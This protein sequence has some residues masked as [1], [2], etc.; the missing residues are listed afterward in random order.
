MN[1]SIALNLTKQL[2]NVTNAPEGIGY[3]IEFYDLMHQLIH[4]LFVVAVIFLLCFIIV[5]FVVKTVTSS[6]RVVFQYFHKIYKGK[7]ITPI[8]YISICIVTA[9]LYLLLYTLSWLFPGVG[10][11]GSLRTSLV[12]VFHVVFR[13]AIII[14]DYV[15]H[16]VTGRP[17]GRTLEE[18][19]VAV[20]ISMLNGQLSLF[21]AL[22]GSIGRRDTA[23]SGT[24]VHLN[25]G[26]LN[27]ELRTAAQETCK[28]KSNTKGTNVGKTNNNRPY[29]TLRGRSFTP[30]YIS[31][32][33]SQVKVYNQEEEDYYY[34]LYDEW[35]TNWD[36]IPDEIEDEKGFSWADEY[37]DGDETWGD[38]VNQAYREVQDMLDDERTTMTDVKM[39]GGFLRYHREHVK[40]G[41]PAKKGKHNRRGQEARET[42]SQENFETDLI[43]FICD[44]I[45]YA[46]PDFEEVQKAVMESYIESIDDPDA[47]LP[48][49]IAVTISKCIYQALTFSDARLLFKK[50]VRR[51]MQVMRLM[52]RDLTL[53]KVTGERPKTQNIEFGRAKDPHTVKRD[54]TIVRGRLISKPEGPNLGVLDAA[55]KYKTV[56]LKQES[57]TIKM[58]HPFFE[59]W[60]TNATKQHTYD[61]CTCCDA[62]G[63]VYAGHIFC[64]DHLISQ[65]YE[66]ISTSIVHVRCLGGSVIPIP[67]HLNACEG[68]DLCPLR[69]RMRRHCN[70]QECMDD[71]LFPG[72]IYRMCIRC[73]EMKPV[74]RFSFS[75]FGNVF[76]ARLCSLCRYQRDITDNPMSEDTVRTPGPL[77]LTC[78]MCNITYA[79]AS[80]FRSRST[81]N[82]SDLCSKC[83]VIRHKSRQPERVQH[84]GCSKRQKEILRMF[85]VGNF[86]GL[87]D[88]YTEVGK[89]TQ[90][91]EVSDNR[92]KI[93]AQAASVDVLEEKKKLPSKPKPQ[94][95]PSSVKRSEQPFTFEAPPPITTPVPKKTIQPVKPA[96]APVY[97]DS[98]DERDE[99]FVACMS[100][101]KEMFEKISERLTRIENERKIVATG[102]TGAKVMKNCQTQTG[103]PKGVSIAIQCDS[104]TVV[105]YP[106][107]KPVKS[108]IVV[109]DQQFL[110]CLDDEIESLTKMNQET[111]L[112][113]EVPFIH[114]DCLVQLDYGGNGRMN[115]VLVGMLNYNSAL[116]VAVLRILTVCHTV[117]KTIFDKTIDK[118]AFCPILAPYFSKILDFATEQNQE[119]PMM[120]DVYIKMQTT[121]Q[122]DSYVLSQKVLPAAK[123]AKPKVGDRVMSFVC[124]EDAKG[125][126]VLGVSQGNVTDVSEAMGVIECQHDASVTTPFTIQGPGS[127]G[128][129]VVLQGTRTLPLGLHFGGICRNN[130][131]VCYTFPHK[132]PPIP[133]AVKGWYK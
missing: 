12:E 19:F 104:E 91:T 3:L 28:R 66:N 37:D 76:Y 98:E 32:G 39:A 67:T 126:V 24:V 77:S 89:K 22:I 100:Q 96:A 7:Y 23:K 26:D 131:N 81:K 108:A 42:Y 34:E 17:S 87:K 85:S 133:R 53:K 5:K 44:H 111:M 78:S 1:C 114:Q 106:K 74:E 94:P 13:P 63:F 30:T 31:I 4:F 62:E 116:S 43:K 45:G 33:N 80:E 49:P 129:L 97:E 121:D 93:K 112:R 115:G 36:L 20:V 92:E 58:D 16:R 90:E 110:E 105:K 88:L 107:T 50:Y 59:A 101:F 65:V 61:H 10:F 47:D 128:S 48:Y 130:Y 124:E 54:G 18:L 84:A 120:C 8:E 132:P 15:S 86:D 41:A 11:G 83:R 68:C 6:H 113:S 109:D 71:Y 117:D 123:S 64:H 70:R 57:R 127:S 2:S 21:V 46:I 56:D 60:K 82:Y 52:D 27:G 102:A 95:A 73:H 75:M 125:R 25:F 79:K 38:Y 9:T 40:P 35:Q 55:A 103:S 14:F 72:G 69:N 29:V 119:N 99:M 122:F 118:V 51:K